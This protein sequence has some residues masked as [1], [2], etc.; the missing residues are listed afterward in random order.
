MSVCPYFHIL[1][2]IVFFF[3]GEVEERSG[4]KVAYPLFWFV[5]ASRFSGIYAYTYIWGVL[6][7]SSVRLGLFRILSLQ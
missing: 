7:T 5:F 4:A 1:G 6:Q 2:G 3:A